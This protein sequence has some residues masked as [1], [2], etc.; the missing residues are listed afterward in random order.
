MK[1][2]LT[3]AVGVPLMLLATFRFSSVA[4][5]VLA[6]TLFGL[7]AIEFVRIGRA[8]APGSVLAL[9]PIGA[10]ALGWVLSFPPMPTQLSGTAVLVV[11][12][13]LVVGAGCAVLFLRTPVEQAPMALGLLTYAI[14]YF[15]LATASFVH[16]QRQ[17]P[18]LVFLLFAIAWLGDTAAY[19]VGS[20]WGRHK[21]APV[22]S[23]KKSW[24]GAAAGFVVSVLA[25]LIWSL[26]FLRRVD[27]AVLAVG[28]LT[29]IAAQVGDL[30]ESLFKRAASIK[31]SGNLL[32]G[33]GGLLDR[34]DAVL[35]AAPVFWLGCLLAADHFRWR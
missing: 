29:A 19:Y 2:L 13:A 28:G 8:W 6:A 34:A 32:P 30:V 20:S 23:P 26:W 17:D 10:V 7:A 15:G 18:W 35:F 24:E 14:P 27:L 11:G 9:V 16:L 31:D 12:L 25:T 33:H 21:L 22:V 3:A 4:Y 1:R 5:F